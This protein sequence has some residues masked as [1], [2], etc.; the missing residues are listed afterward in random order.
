MQQKEFRKILSKV[1]F[2]YNEYDFGSSDSWCVWVCI[3]HT[4][5]SMH[6]LSQKYVLP[7]FLGA[8]DAGN[9]NSVMLSG[10]TVS[11]IPA[12]DEKKT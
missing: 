2:Y 7:I 5:P 11:E 10:D 9:K 3:F 6:K 4:F 8:S 1:V 12:V